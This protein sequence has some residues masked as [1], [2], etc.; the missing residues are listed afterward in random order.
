MK[1]W[2]YLAAQ[3]KLIGKTKNEENEAILEVVEI[4]WVQSNLM[5]DQYQQKSEVLYFFTSNKFYA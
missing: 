5:N 1:H 2:N 4:V 3:K